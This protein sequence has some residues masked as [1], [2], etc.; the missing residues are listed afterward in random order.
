MVSSCGAYYFLTIVDDYTRV[1]WVFLMIAKSE[2][3]RL[4]KDFCSMVQTQFSK[5]VKILRSDDGQEFTCLSHFY[6]ENGILHQTSCVDTPP[7]E[8]S[9]RNKTP[10]Y[11][12]CCS[13]LA[14]SSQLTY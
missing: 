12:K 4:I 11:S 1:V 8:W 7:T 6:A 2:V 3:G 10:T 13:S 5:Q 9:G 14:I